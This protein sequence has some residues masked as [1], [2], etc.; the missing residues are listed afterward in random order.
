[1]RRLSNAFHILWV[2]VVVLVFGLLYGLVR[3]GLLLGLCWSGARRRR[4]VARV[5]GWAL[6]R[7]MESL[8]ASFIKMGQVMSTR[9]DLL[10]PETIE[11]LKRLQDRLP[12]FSFAKVKRT[13][14]EDT[15]KP[16]AETFSELDEQPVAAASVA[17]VHRA[18]LKDGREVAVKVLR[19]NVRRQVER[20]AS[21][22]LFGA[23]VIALHPR[24]K[25]SDPVG[26]TQHFVEAIHDQ[27]DLR[28]EAANYRKFHGNFATWTT[29]KF[30]EVL[31]PAT[32]RVLTMEFIRGTKI[33]AQPADRRLPLAEVVRRCMFQMCFDDG[34]LHADMHPGNMLVDEEG[35]LVLFDVGLAKHLH[36]DVLI[37]FIDMGKCLTMG[38][39]GDLVAH[40]RRFHTYMGDVD[41]DALSKEVDVFALKFRNQSA[42]DLDYG[43]LFN[44][45]FAIG[46]RY[47]VRPV[48]DMTLVLV[49]MVTSQGIGK[50]LDPEVN[51][52]AHVARHLVPILMKRNERVPDT[53]SAREAQ[54]RP[55]APS[56]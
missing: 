44:E 15:G 46:R 10:A 20:D 42:N 47:H 11:Q 52:F 54:A 5:N 31:A 37:Q 55:P 48:T 51:V 32:E 9:P 8:G 22:L 16:L 3:L 50:M 36:E 2:G 34:F 41:W 40:L 12:A 28:I 7:S 35:R 6:R 53:D 33:D 4:V 23:K 30:P 27:T 19:P 13:I 29:V 26:H 21:L 18:R 43:K 17:Q 56:H 14:E 39:P 45:M 24:L 38:T 1:V 49:A 25:R